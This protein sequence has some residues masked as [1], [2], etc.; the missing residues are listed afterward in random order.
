M[1]YDADAMPLTR[2]SLLRLAGAALAPAARAESAAPQ[3]SF[4]VDDA[5]Y[6][7][8]YDAAVRAA[9]ANVLTLSRYKE[10]VLIEGGP[11]RGV[12][13]E[14]APQEGQVYAPWNAAAAAANQ[15]SFFALQR[16][17]GQLP[18]LIHANRLG[19]AQIQMVVPIAAT[20][21]EV[22]ESTG[23]AQLLEQSYAAC[24]GWDNWLQRYRNTRATGLCELFCEYDT[25]HD[26]SPR[27]SG[28]PHAC[29]DGE[30]RNLPAGNELPWL[31]PDLSATVYGGRIA[32]ARAA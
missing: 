7:A 15:R 26:R 27:L 14:C 21:L 25:G 11:Y 13:L 5:K 19:Y 17:D 23:D 4:R 29:P 9:E 8:V 20:A 32:L 2:R 12:W 3:P 16:A 1:G 10:P 28:L 22:A 18:C 30:A 24:A 31:A 6:Q